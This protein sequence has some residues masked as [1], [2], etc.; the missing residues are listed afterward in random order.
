MPELSPSDALVL[1]RRVLNDDELSRLV[2]EDPTAA[3]TT[4]EVDSDTVRGLQYVINAAN[5]RS[6]DFAGGSGG[7][8]GGE[9]PSPGGSTEIRELM[10]EPYGHIRQTFYVLVGMSVTMFLVGVALMVVAAVRAADQSEVTAE[11]LALA[12]VGLADLTVL[13]YR[14][15]WLDV[16]RSLSN[17]QQT[18]MVSTTYLAGLSLIRDGDDAAISALSKMTAEL[19]DMLEDYTESSTDD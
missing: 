16:L 3:S 9:N 19:V 5:S 10:L 13:F 6:V 11:T 7:G 2:Q 17:T 1:A 14:R 8:A 4:L 18:R 12:G 15:P